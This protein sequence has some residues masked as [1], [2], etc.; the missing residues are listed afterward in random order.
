MYDRTRITR[1]LIRYSSHL[2][3]FAS[4]PMPPHPPLFFRLDTVKSSKAVIR[5]KEP[6]FKGGLEVRGPYED[7]AENRQEKA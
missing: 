6:L 3:C 5:W 1:L 2:S 4:E 7:R